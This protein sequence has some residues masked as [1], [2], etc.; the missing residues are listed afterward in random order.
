MLHLQP[1]GQ[2]GNDAGIDIGLAAGIEP[3]LVA[4]RVEQHLQSFPEG[5][6]TEVVQV[7]LRDGA[8]HD[9]VDIGHR[10]SPFRTI[11]VSIL[12]PI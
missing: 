10:V 7:G 11:R 9:L 5:V 6:V 2:R 4:Q 12:T 8:G 1:L 3:C